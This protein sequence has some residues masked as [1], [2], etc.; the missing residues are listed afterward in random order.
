LRISILVS[1]VGGG[2][3][4]AADGYVAGVAVILISIPM[5]VLCFSEVLLDLK[6]LFG[7]APKP[8]P[9]VSRR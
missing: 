5:A 6:A 3:A 1:G 8:S 7:I 9:N 2:I 4:A